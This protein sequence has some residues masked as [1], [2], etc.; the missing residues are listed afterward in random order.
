[1]KTTSDLKTEQDNGLKMMLKFDWQIEIYGAVN[2]HARHLGM[3]LN[4]LN[5]DNFGREVMP[6]N[7]FVAG[8]TSQLENPFNGVK[9]LGCHVDYTFAKNVLTFQVMQSASSVKRCAT[10]T[11]KKKHVP[12]ILF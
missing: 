10:T 3:G 9:S 6:I 2:C 5:A 11:R 1:M 12:G 4:G 7:L 8:S